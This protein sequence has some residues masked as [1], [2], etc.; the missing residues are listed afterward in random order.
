MCDSEPAVR[1]KLFQPE[2]LSDIKESL[3]RKLD[4]GDVIFNLQHHMYEYFRKEL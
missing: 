1:R 3:S 4:L 2:E